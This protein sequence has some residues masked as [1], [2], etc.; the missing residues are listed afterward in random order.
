MS[1]SQTAILPGTGPR[2]MVGQAIGTVIAIWLVTVCVLAASGVFVGGP[3]KPPLAVFGCA[4]VPMI[5]FAMA[6]RMSQV[7]RDFLLALD[8]RLI[9]GIQAWRF[10]GFGF[11][12]LYAGHLLPGLFALP[13]GLGDMAI[14]IAAP[15]WLAALFKNPGAASG[16]RFRIWNMLG[17]LDFVI[18]FTT[19]TICAMTI[20]GSAGPTIAPMGQLPLVLI[21]VFMVPLFAMLHI[22]AL[23]QAKR[24][25]Q[26]PYSVGEI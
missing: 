20:A 11:I 1:N 22:T 4:V 5:L 3:G 19:A 2:P 18:A 10:G 16:R 26:S 21:P 14:G 12:V 15:V 25:G 17:L 9:V 23:M 7:F 13:A 8:V 6:W 24:V